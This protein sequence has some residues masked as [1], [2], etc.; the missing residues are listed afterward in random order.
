MLQLRTRGLAKAVGVC[1]F[2]TEHLAALARTGREMPEVL[3][4]ELHLANQQSLGGAP[5]SAQCFGAWGLVSQRDLSHFC[6]QHHIALMAATPLA[7]GQLARSERGSRAA[8]L[9]PALIELAELKQRTAAEVAIRWCLQQGAMAQAATQGAAECNL[10]YELMLNLE[11]HQEEGDFSRGQFNVCE[12]TAKESNAPFGLRLSE[13]E[14]VVEP[15]DGGAEGM[16]QVQ[17]APE[18]AVADIGPLQVSDL[19]LL[20][21]VNESRRT[22]VF[23]LLGQLH[24]HASQ[25]W[26]FLHAV[27]LFFLFD[28]ISFPF[29]WLCGW[30]TGEDRLLLRYQVFPKPDAGTPT[31]DDLITDV[32]LGPS[33]STQQLALEI[34]TPGDSDLK[35]SHLQA[36]KLL[37]KGDATSFLQL[38]RSYVTPRSL[39]PKLSTRAEELKALA[40]C[41]AQPSLEAPSR[42]ENEKS[43]EQVTPGAQKWVQ[44]YIHFDGRGPLYF[45]DWQW[46]TWFWYCGRRYPLLPCGIGLIFMAFLGVL[47]DVVC[48]PFVGL[49]YLTKG[50]QSSCLAC[51]GEGKHEV[52][53]YLYTHDQGGEGI[54]YKTEG[55]MT[56]L[57]TDYQ[58][59][60]YITGFNKCCRG[61]YQRWGKKELIRCFQVPQ[62]IQLYQDFGCYHIV[63]GE[64]TLITA[65]EML[66]KMQ[67]IQ[68]TCGCCC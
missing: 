57:R 29:R 32:L 2:S 12:R 13:E 8:P 18:M 17:A 67:N 58:G 59:P 21:I 55:Y 44:A 7:R 37:L 19:A 60:S 52:K 3:Q 43:E 66:Q 61:S 5:C 45:F 15:M 25:C 51:D 9:A 11:L 68:T 22:P 46:G 56:V 16:A 6:R 50:K 47:A 40:A 54:E 64:L 34:I 1:N 49:I 39:E 41:V 27:I 20:R 4:V 26:M 33:V 30:K 31:S 42:R 23:L 14:P 24:R 65:D 62:E 48:A 28:L 38:A 53:A 63:A 35:E 36:L 10:L